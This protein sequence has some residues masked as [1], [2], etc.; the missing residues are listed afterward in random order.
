VTEPRAAQARVEAPHIS[1]TK[2]TTMTK[3]DQKRITPQDAC[4]F[5]DMCITASTKYALSNAPPQR[6]T[7]PRVTD[8]LRIER[9]GLR[10]NV[11]N[12]IMAPAPDVPLIYPRPLIAEV[13]MYMEDALRRHD[14][15]TPYFAECTG[16]GLASVLHKHSSEV[17]GL[18]SQLVRYGESSPQQDRELC[19]SLVN[20]LNYADLVMVRMGLTS[21]D[22]LPA[23]T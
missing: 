14:D 8:C 2:E 20:V 23:K 9:D 7:D 10:D 15:R 3:T 22:I 5:L 18:V 16:D 12:F 4:K 13:A 11:R 1:Q 6:P 19:K 17:S 21:S